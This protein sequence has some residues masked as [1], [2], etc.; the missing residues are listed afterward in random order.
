MKVILW[1]SDDP[2]SITVEFWKHSHLFAMISSIQLNPFHTVD[3]YRQAI[4]IDKYLARQFGNGYSMLNSTHIEQL[5][6]LG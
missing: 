2:V 3:L 4:Y 6:K 1:K 5:R